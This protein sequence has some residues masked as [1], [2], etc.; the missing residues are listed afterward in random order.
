MTKMCDCGKDAG[1]AIQVR[2]Y[3]SGCVFDV[4]MKKA[5]GIYSQ[6]LFHGDGGIVTA[7]MPNICDA[8]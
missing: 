8:P 5:L 3:S 7:Y 6:R 1:I 4:Q 2:S